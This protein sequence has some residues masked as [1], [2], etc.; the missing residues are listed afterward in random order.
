MA[1]ERAPLIQKGPIYGIPLLDTLPLG[2]GC[3]KQA[4]PNRDDLEGCTNTRVAAGYEVLLWHYQRQLQM[5]S[6]LAV[7]LAAERGQTESEVK[8]WIEDLVDDALRASV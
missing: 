7:E 1:I 5:C 3:M 2:R 8:Q 4:L 6:R